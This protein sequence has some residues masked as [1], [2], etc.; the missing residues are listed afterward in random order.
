MTKNSDEKSRFLLSLTLGLFFFS[1]LNFAHCKPFQTKARLSKRVSSTDRACDSSW[2]SRDWAKYET[3]YCCPENYGEYIMRFVDD[4]AICF[5]EP[6]T[7]EPH[8][9]DTTYC[10]EPVYQRQA[11]CL[12]GYS[13]FCTYGKWYRNGCNRWEG[14]KTISCP[15]ESYWYDKES[16]MCIELSSLGKD[17]TK[18]LTYNEYLNSKTSLEKLFNNTSDGLVKSQV[19]SKI[20]KLNT[21]YPDY[22]RGETQ[23]DYLPKA[24]PSGNGVR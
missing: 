13:R 10:A 6:K 23:E 2:V 7:V 17:N 14:E 24:L 20:L 3:V 18:I 9:N 19:K 21:K 5:S 16:E 4:K 15:D 8:V 22:A 12:G 1:F 11:K